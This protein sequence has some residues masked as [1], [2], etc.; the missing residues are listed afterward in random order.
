[1]SKPRIPS[2]KG[3]RDT[4]FDQ[5]GDTFQVQNGRPVRVLSK[6]ESPAHPERGSRKNI[7]RSLKRPTVG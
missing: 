3:E 5:N 2:G 4:F 6:N 7:N 1:M